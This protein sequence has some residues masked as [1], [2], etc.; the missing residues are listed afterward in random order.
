MRPSEKRTPYFHSPPIHTIW[1]GAAAGLY[2]QT[3]TPRYGW[4]RMVYFYWEVS[5]AVLGHLSSLQ[6][7]VVLVL[8]PIVSPGGNEL[9]LF[10]Q[11]TEYRNN[12]PTSILVGE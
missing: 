3:R 11:C 1:C 12:I 6:P 4:I 2:L 7:V 10:N 9:E 8:I 5:G